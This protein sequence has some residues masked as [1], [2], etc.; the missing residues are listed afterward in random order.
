MAG[1]SS[2]TQGVQRPQK[3]QTHFFVMTTDK[4]E[5]NLDTVIGI[6]FVFGTPVCVFLILG[7]VGRL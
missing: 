2:K 3:T 6:I 7:P 1:S 5:A 4:L